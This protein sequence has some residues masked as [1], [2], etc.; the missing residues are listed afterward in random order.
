M[1]GMLSV[2]AMSMVHEHMHQR[3]SE[4]QQIRQYSQH[5]RAMLG[6]QQETSYCEK[7]IEHPTC[8]GTMLIFVLLSHGNLLIV[9]HGAAAMHW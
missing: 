5:V 6:K 7:S 9:K 2:P 4:Q 3:A 8:S 1:M